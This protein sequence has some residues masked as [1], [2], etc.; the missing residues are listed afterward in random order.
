VAARQNR[1]NAGQAPTFCDDMQRL[2]KDEL[3]I[4]PSAETAKLYKELMK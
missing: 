1:N 3:G 2:L 4:T